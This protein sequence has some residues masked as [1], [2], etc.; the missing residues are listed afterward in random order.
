MI[1]EAKNQTYVTFKRNK[2]GQ[3]DISKIIINTKSR[4]G[5]PS[6]ALWGSP[7]NADY[8]WKDYCGR[9]CEEF[10]DTYDW[11][12]PI[13]WRLKENSKIYQIDIADVELNQDNPLLNYITIVNDKLLIEETIECTNEEKLEYIEDYRYDVLINFFKMKEDGIVAVEL[14]NACIGHYFENRLETMF[15]GWDCESI[16]VLDPSKII[17]L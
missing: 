3:F 12:N 13:K 2:F 16:C 10:S 17:W 1:V 7:E 8:S 15:N 11:D 4:N 5:K 6:K 9:E 14:M